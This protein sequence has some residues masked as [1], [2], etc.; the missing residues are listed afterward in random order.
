MRTDYLECDPF[1]LQDLRGRQLQEQVQPL[2][3]LLSAVCSA[4]RPVRRFCR[5]TVLP[6]L[7]S[8]VLS[9][10]QFGGTLRNR[11]LPRSLH[12]P[13]ITC[14][15][16]WYVPFLLSRFIIFVADSARSSRVLSLMSLVLQLIFSL[17]SA[18]KTVNKTSW[19][20][21]KFHF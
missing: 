11:L 18:K 1:P 12:F 2:L 7:T 14:G 4:S 13:G 5:L 21:G 20:I 15:S 19:L 16:I 9:L 6:P 10:P 17:S 8:E 3:A